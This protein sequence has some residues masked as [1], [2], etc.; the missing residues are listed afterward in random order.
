MIQPLVHFFDIF[1]ATTAA[2]VTVTAIF[3]MKPYA[4]LPDPVAKHAT[5][6]I[7]FH[8]KMNGNIV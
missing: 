5:D 4:A 1:M 7:R 8:V 2:T 6:S 3:L